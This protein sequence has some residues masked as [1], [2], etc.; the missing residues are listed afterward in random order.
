MAKP[1]LS[2]QMPK[3][4]PA[5]KF[6]TLC[7]LSIAL[8]MLDRKFEA[9][10]QVRNVAASLTFPLQWIASKPVELYEHLV[11]LTRSQTKLKA[12]NQ[13]LSAENIRLQAASHKSQ[14]L[15]KQVD[16]LKSILHLKQTGFDSA[17]P[18]EVVSNGGNPFSDLLVIDKG[19]ES[20]I[21]AGDAV[22]DRNGL[23]GQVTQVRRFSSDIRLISSNELVVPVAISRTGVRSLTFGEGNRLS[24][25]YFPTDADLQQGDLLLTSGIDSVYPPG[26]PVA[27]V[28]EASKE[29][30]SPYY[31]ARLETASALQASKY[32]LVIA[33]KPPASAEASR[34]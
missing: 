27:T 18:A 6:F 2:F 26:I 28:K 1:S 17:V 12:Q 34:P 8:L 13:A 5:G 24:L 31:Q 30:G 16:D 32:L 14:S 4:T 29:S 10:Q 33:Q 11:L 9:V 25:L 20:G 3:R 19:Q 22:I 15:Q 21:R 7:L 23:V